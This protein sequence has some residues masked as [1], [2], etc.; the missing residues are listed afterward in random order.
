MAKDQQ[1]CNHVNVFVT[2][3]VLLLQDI[4]ITFILASVFGIAG[5][6]A[7]YMAVQWARLIDDGIEVPG[8]DPEAL[9]KARDVLAATAVSES[10]TI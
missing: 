1:H 6:L 10:N 9:P 8:A 2:S 5:I 7:A 4:V 3:V